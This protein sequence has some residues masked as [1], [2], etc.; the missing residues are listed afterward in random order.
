MAALQ[1]LRDAPNY[2]WEETLGSLARGRNP[3]GETG[4]VRIRS[5][6]RVSASG[7]TEQGG[8]T[9][10][11]KYYGRTALGAGL[12][13][14]TTAKNGMGK[15]VAELPG[16]WMTAD[17]IIQTQAALSRPGSGGVRIDRAFALARGA[18]AELTPEEELGWLVNRVE[19]FY[20]AGNYIVGDLDEGAR[21]NVGRRAGVLTPAHRA[22]IV[23][24]IEQG[25]I[26]EYLIAVERSRRGGVF[27]PPQ[28][29]SLGPLV[30]LR[31]I[32]STTVLVPPGALERLL[33]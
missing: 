32:G 31:D 30:K 18:L 16:G 9:V 27:S 7:Q 33:P 22:E 29:E 4:S 14:L 11:T 13:K 6:G 3:L 25:V 10:R 2:S 26:R 5:F 1:A 8:F 15:G 28:L 23:L 20:Q 19:R 17:E 21:R 12:D 24:R